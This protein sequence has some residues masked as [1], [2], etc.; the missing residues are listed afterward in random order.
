MKFSAISI[1]VP[2]SAQRYFHQ[3]LLVMKLTTFL[4]IIGLLQVSARGYSQITLH[5]KNVSLEKVFN[6]IQKQTSYNFLYD[7]H[8]LNIGLVTID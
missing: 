6:A 7:E 5:E 8:Q 3:I 4:L 1:A 2:K